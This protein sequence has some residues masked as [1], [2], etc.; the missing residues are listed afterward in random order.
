MYLAQTR[1]ETVNQQLHYTYTI[2]C[3]ERFYGSSREHRKLV[4][5]SRSE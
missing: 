2:L 1:I 3:R 4:I 5:I